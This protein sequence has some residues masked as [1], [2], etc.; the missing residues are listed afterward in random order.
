VKILILDG[1]LNP[2]KYQNSHLPDPKLTIMNVNRAWV[3]A[4]SQNYVRAKFRI[5]R[6]LRRETYNIKAGMSTKRAQYYYNTQPLPSDTA[7]ATKEFK[8]SIDDDWKTCLAMLP[9]TLDYFFSIVDR[10][11]PDDRHL[12]MNYLREGRNGVTGHD[13]QELKRAKEARQY[14]SDPA[15]GW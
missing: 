1:Q 15:D 2:P 8:E 4:H 7:N 5:L 9:D 14:Q 11:I 3:L 12:D 10:T 13:L 6:N